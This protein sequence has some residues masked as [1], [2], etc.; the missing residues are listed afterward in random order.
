MT[1]VLVLGQSGQLAQALLATQP[2]GIEV[3]AWGRS[4][5]DLADT[6]AI[7]PS[8]TAYAP[9]VIINASA[10]TS[11]DRAEQESDAAFALNEMAV[12][13]VGRAA[14]ELGCGLVHVSTDFVFDGCQSHPYRPE[15]A[16]APLGVYGLSKRA[17]EQ[18]LLEVMPTAAIVRTAWVYRAGSACFLT[19]MLRLMSERDEL[20]VVCDQIGTPTSADNLAAVLWQVARARLSGI[21]HYT[22]AGAASWYDFACAILRQAQAIGLLKK[23]P[24]VKPIRTDQ[25]PTPATRPSYSVLDASALWD[26]LGL[27]AEHWQGAL[28]TQ[29]SVLLRRVN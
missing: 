10:Y 13:E 20:G 27:R 16:C 29:L 6:A 22:D 4:R 11:V 21:W 15:D 19:T 9:D 18:A 24:T 5:L 1:R 12:R 2:G 14:A 23:Q 7:M 28:A 3:E 17:G 25:Y 8:L 26:R